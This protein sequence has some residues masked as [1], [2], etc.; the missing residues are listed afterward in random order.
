MA[1]QIF[2]IEASYK[3][4]LCICVL[5]LFKNATA[6]VDTIALNENVVDTI[7]ASLDSTTKDTLSNIWT[8]DNFKNQSVEITDFKKKQP[9]ADGWFFIL[10]L[11]LLLIFVLKYFLFNEYVRKSWNAWVNNNLFFQFVRE[12]QPINVLIF[13]FE[14]ALK[15]YVFSILFFLA[16]FL[17]TKH[18]QLHWVDFRNILLII[19]VF[20]AVKYLLTFMQPLLPTS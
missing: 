18:W 10:N 16:K 7:A 15:V 17:I 4:M 3:V 19:S 9:F 12:K 8:F 1:K 11:V 2:K 6:Q 14:F 13:A 5:M 20:F